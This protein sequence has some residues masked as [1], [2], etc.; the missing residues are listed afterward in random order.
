MLPI[1]LSSRHSVQTEG[2]FRQI[3]PTCVSPFVDHWA[4]D[5]V[6][7]SLLPRVELNTATFESMC[8]CCFA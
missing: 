5:Q 1:E 8:S 4:E 7:E 3:D 6:S 2:S